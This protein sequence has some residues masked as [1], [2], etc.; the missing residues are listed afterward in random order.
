MTQV[1]TAFIFD[2]DGT[3]FDSVDQIISAANSTRI[4]FG[5]E[6]KEK[7]FYIPAIGLLARNLPLLQLPRFPYL[8]RLHHQRVKVGKFTDF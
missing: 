5:Y 3:L 2:M 4:Q 1:R 8:I 6:T 7:E